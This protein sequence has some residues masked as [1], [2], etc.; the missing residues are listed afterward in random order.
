[1]NPSEEVRYAIA[2][3]LLHGLSLTAALRVYRHYG[4]A[5]EAYA[6][7]SEYEG[8]IGKGQ[9]NWEEAL[10]RADVE[11]QF[12]ERHNVRAL[13]YSAPDYPARLRE[14]PDPPLVL[15]Y[16][17]TANLNAQH[18][19]A[20]VGTRHISNYGK[21]VCQKFSAE[22]HTLLPDC[23]LVSGLAY[24]VDIHSQRGYLEAGGETVG[25]LAHGLDRIYPPAH[26][27]TAKQMVAQGG[28]LTEYV[29]TTVPDKGNFVRRNRIIAGVSDAVVVV[30]SAA[31]GGALITARLA[32]DYDREVF[33][34]P[35]RVGD[36]YSEGCNALIR[37]NCAALITSA[38]DLAQ[39]LNWAVKEKAAQPVQRELFPELSDEQRR[40]C[41]HL[42]GTEG[43]A[44]NRLAIDLNIPVQQLTASLF[45]LEMSGVVRLL[46]GGR[47]R[48]VL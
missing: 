28:L 22:L 11:I 13:P 32:R 45:D 40:I 41:A 16:C 30:E 46:P 25:V 19:I 27:T 29:T 9:L 33:A 34:F 44:L 48:L 23:L 6:H 31:R 14:C 7:R 5:T 12:C 43:V 8:Q 18:V 39:A 38:A 1:M 17:G 2:L 3:T 26:R 37:D 42:Q 15:F 21:D 36:Q 20:V 35:G 4:S 10:H 47:Y 24:G